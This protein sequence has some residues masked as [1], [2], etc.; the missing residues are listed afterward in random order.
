MEEE[1]GPRRVLESSFGGRRAVGRPRA[2]W[3]DAVKVD[4]NTFLGIRNYK[5]ATRN[6]EN[7]KKKIGEARTRLEL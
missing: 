6:M 3:K 5:T 7:W 1:R 2:R 4:A